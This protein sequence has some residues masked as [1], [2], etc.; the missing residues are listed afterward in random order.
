[1]CMAC[2]GTG[3]PRAQPDGDCSLA[4]A[5]RGGHEEL[6]V[7]YDARET[8]AKKSVTF[9]HSHEIV[10]FRKDAKFEA[11]NARIIRNKRRSY[12]GNLF[13]GLARGRS[14]GHAARRGH[15]G[16]GGHGGDGGNADA[17][18]EGEG[19]GEAPRRSNSPNL[20][21]VSCRLLPIKGSRRRGRSD[22]NR[23]AHLFE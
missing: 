22:A 23:S 20:D 3:S 4:A 2:D 11:Q 16:H 5:D 1:M 19:E 18:E 9:S 13:A 7:Y 8:F 14:R 21:V 15:G 17:D 10:F 6:D 12:L